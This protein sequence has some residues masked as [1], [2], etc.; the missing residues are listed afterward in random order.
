MA[1]DPDELKFAVTPD[2]PPFPQTQTQHT[3]MPDELMMLRLFRC[4]SPKNRQGT[5]AEM[6]EKL[7]EDATIEDR[8][9]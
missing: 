4:L 6:L 7:V 5:V 2:Y 3:L 8:E 9:E 1:L